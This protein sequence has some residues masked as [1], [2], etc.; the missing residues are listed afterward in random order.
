[1]LYDIVLCIWK[2]THGHLL[3][4]LARILLRQNSGEKCWM[5]ESTLR[6]M[7]VDVIDFGCIRNSN[8]AG[9]VLVITKWLILICLSSP[10]SASAYYLLTKHHGLEPL[11]CRL[12]M[13]VTRIIIITIY[14]GTCTQF[15][16]KCLHFTFFSNFV[17]WLKLNIGMISLNQEQGKGISS[18][19][20]ARRKY[21]IFTWTKMPCPNL[22]H[23][24]WKHNTTRIPIF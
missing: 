17:S 16:N 10:H 24:L 3:Q 2:P 19:A 8:I 5:V 13:Q 4:I 6:A 14:T 23:F 9:L 1:M 21:T 12:F 7:T 22:F 11:R 18:T 20:E 15:I